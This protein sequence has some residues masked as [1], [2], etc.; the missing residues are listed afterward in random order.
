M[1]TML[2]EDI[3]TRDAIGNKEKE[4]RLRLREIERL[5]VEIIE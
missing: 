2:K 3:L 1:E 4:I 5:I